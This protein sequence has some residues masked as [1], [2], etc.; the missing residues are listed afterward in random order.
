MTW[1][2]VG[3]VVIFFAV[4]VALF[5]FAAYKKAKTQL[6]KCPNC[7]ND[8]KFYKTVMKCPKCKTKILRHDDGTYHI[9]T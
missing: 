4:V 1:I 3:I 7:D 2:F 8:V 9:Q 6:T 5:P